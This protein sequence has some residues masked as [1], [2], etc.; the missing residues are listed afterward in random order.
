MYTIFSAVLRQQRKSDVMTSFGHSAHSAVYNK[1]GSPYSIKG[2]L[3]EQFFLFF[4][5]LQI[6]F[7]QLFK[8]LFLLL[9]C[10][11]AVF[12]HFYARKGL[13][14]LTSRDQEVSAA[15]SFII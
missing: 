7:P 11:N 2:Y 1:A 5:C 9:S 8:I 13:I 15:G 4:F 12:S 6:M 10:R 3:L 14:Q